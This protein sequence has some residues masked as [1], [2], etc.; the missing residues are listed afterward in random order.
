MGYHPGLFRSGSRSA[1]YRG[2][3]GYFLSAPILNT[4]NFPFD[5]KKTLNE[6]YK[7]MGLATN[8][9]SHQIIDKTAKITSKYEE[10]NDDLMHHLSEALR[11]VEKPLKPILENVPQEVKRTRFQSSREQDFLREIIA[12]YGNDYSR[13]KH[14]K[15]NV[16]QL[17]EGQLRKKCEKYLSL[18]QQQ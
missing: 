6:N 17:T 9:N 1:N 12:K 7:D 16:L 10:D 8:L 15:L 11:S 4:Q 14:D 5:M 3:G 13:M 18:L 2:E